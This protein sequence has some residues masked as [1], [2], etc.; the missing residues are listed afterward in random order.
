MRLKWNWF[1]L[2]ERDGRFYDMLDF[3]TKIIDMMEA[4]RAQPVM[5]LVS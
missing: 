1:G 5:K 4:V 2:T 3:T